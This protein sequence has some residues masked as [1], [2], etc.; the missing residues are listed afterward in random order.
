VR[1][2][3]RG[4]SSD[5]SIFPNFAIDRAL[6]ALKSEGLLGSGS[7][8][9]VGILGPGLDFTDKREGY[10][11]YPQQTLQPF[12]VMDSLIRLG[13]ARRDDLRTTTFDLSPRINQH[14]EVARQRARANGA[15]VLQLPRDTNSR[16]NQDLAA[17]WERLG[18]TIGEETKAL[19]APLG[20]GSV[21]VRAVRI[22][23]EVVLTI[24]PQDLDIVLQRLEP[25][26]PGPADERFDVIIATNLLIYYEVFE[27][28]L[29]LANVARMLRPGG[30]FL[31]N[32]P[33]VILPTMPMDSVGFIE[34]VYSSQLNDRDR[35]VWYQR[36]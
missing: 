7:V 13:L 31:T 20:L 6:E 3:E 26:P 21:R 1:F 24:D 35:I 11:F 34:A 2:D 12:A 14:L 10:D 23:P 22:P 25:L 36:R 19:E 5:T 27:Q 17:Y 30:F 4:L 32:T 33:P 8:R 16:W 29:A 18:D 9:R 28:S 15:Y